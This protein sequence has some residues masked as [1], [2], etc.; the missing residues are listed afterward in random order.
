MK[1][2]VIM[3]VAAL[4]ILA[5]T[6]QRASAWKQFKFGV[7]LNL[8]GSGGGNNL[9]W[10]LYKSQQPPAQGYGGYQ[11][12]QGSPYG[13]NFGGYGGGMGGG[14]GGGFGGLGYNIGTETAPPPLA[15]PGGPQSNKVQPVNYEFDPLGGY[16]LPVG[17]EGYTPPSYWPGW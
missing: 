14:F 8:E 10:G 11:G 16:G 9:L 15:L 17:Y 6:S 3:S 1:K 7:G 4:T 13:P 12:P 5:L 2:L